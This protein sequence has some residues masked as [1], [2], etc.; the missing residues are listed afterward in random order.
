MN[1][2]ALLR[3]IQGL[4]LALLIDAKHDRMLGWIQVQADD[5]DQLLGKVRIVGELERLHAMRLEVGLLPHPLHH[6][7][8]RAQVL[9]QRPR[10][11]MRGGGRLL[12]NGRFHNPRREFL[13]GRRRTTAAWGI[14]FNSGQPPRGEAVAPQRD[15]LPQR[16]QFVGDLL[17][18]LASGGG[19]HNLRRSTRRASTLRPRAN[20]GAWLVHRPST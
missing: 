16:A 20:A 3:T 1:G 8:R 11:P 6:R 10:A 17:V 14:L 18:L 7:R 9:G 4:N 19:Q 13:F 15:R 5:V 2:Q 12:G